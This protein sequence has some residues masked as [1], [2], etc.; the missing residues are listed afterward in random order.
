M[1]GVLSR[2]ALTTGWGTCL[3]RRRR[4]RVGGAVRTGARND[5]TRVGPLDPRLTH[6][7]WRS[8][9]PCQGEGEGGSTRSPPAPRHRTRAPLGGEGQGEGDTP[10]PTHPAPTFCASLPL[11]GGGSGRGSAAPCTT[12][13]N[14]RSPLPSGERVRVRGGNA[15]CPSR[16]TRLLG[17]SSVTRVP[18]HHIPP[19]APDAHRIAILTPSL[20][21]RTL[22]DSL[23]FHE[24]ASLTHCDYTPVNLS[25]RGTL[26][27]LCTALPPSDPAPPP[28]LSP[29]PRPKSRPCLPCARNSGPSPSET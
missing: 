11:P 10:N 26:S 9:P 16:P 19:T 8:P 21:R 25:L 5:R 12:S 28:S 15:P 7:I 2:L 3:P 4:V 17:Q 23:R 14:T 1:G 29:T 13:Q 18:T 24:S 20:P 22:R 27:P 6:E